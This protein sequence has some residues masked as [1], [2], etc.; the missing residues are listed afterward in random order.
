MDMIQRRNDDIVKTKA[1]KV[2]RTVNGVD[3]ERKPSWISRT[4]SG[5]V[6]LQKEGYDTALSDCSLFAV[7]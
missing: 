6:L 2:K 7:E 4:G 3:D 5:R 1:R